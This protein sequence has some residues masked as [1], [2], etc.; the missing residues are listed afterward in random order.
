MVTKFIPATAPAAAPAGSAS[1]KTIIAVFPPSS[2]DTSLTPA[3]AAS[4]W[5]DLP[6]APDR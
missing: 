1:P 6:V 5:T 2:S 4:R 3:S